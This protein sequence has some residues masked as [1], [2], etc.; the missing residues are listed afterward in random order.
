MSR[1]RTTASRQAKHDAAVLRDLALCRDAKGKVDLSV[2]PPGRRARVA[3]HLRD[4]ARIMGET[5]RK[6]AE[7]EGTA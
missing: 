1:L 7:K 4:V 5:A 3:R 2:L 6:M